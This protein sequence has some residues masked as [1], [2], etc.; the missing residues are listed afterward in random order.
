MCEKEQKEAIEEIEEQPEVKNEPPRNRF[1]LTEWAGA[2]GDLGTFIPFVVGYIAIVD[3]NPLGI[4]LTIGVFLIISGVVYKT[5]FPVQPMKAIGGAAISQA[6]L[7]TPNMVWAAGLFTGVFWLV[8]ALTGVLKYITKLVSKPVVKGIVLGLGISFILQ[9]TTMMRTDIIIAVIALVL[10]IVLFSNRFVPAMFALLLF[11]VVVTLIRS[12][13]SVQEFL[14]IRPSVYIP[15]FALST[16]SWSD[17]LTGIFIL[18][19]PQIPL[20]LGNTVIA[21]TSENNRIFPDRPVSEKKVTI[22]MSIM[23]LLSPVIGGIPICHGAGGLASHVRFGAKTGGAVIILGGFLL[24]LGLF[25]SDSVILIFEMIPP[26]VLGVML[27]FAGVEL[28]MSARDVSREK[29]D[30]FILLIT[31]GFAVWNVGIGFLAG[32]IMQVLVKR[33]WFKDNNL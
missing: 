13:V 7:I 30:F 14:S 28:A 32:L 11:G 5:P 1:N 4:L 8:I 33:K 26:A 31:A 12:P 6:A 17:M 20:T 18:A 27:F 23:N 21:A 25:F 10:T 29:T 24:I 2:F 22:S 9:A 3:I 16:L 19:I 15:Q